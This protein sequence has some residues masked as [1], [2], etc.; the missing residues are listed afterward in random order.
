M[1]RVRDQRALH[2]PVTRARRGRKGRDRSRVPLP[3]GIGSVAPAA[4][5]H[6][7]RSATPPAA[8]H[9][10]CQT[11][12]QGKNDS[13]GGQSFCRN[14][15][16]QRIRWCRAGKPPAQAG[17]IP[18][19]KLSRQPTGRFHKEQKWI[20]SWLTHPG[21]SAQECRVESDDS[22]LTK[23]SGPNAGQFPHWKS[24]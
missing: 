19:F 9:S 24:G 18:R 6:S 13:L 12:A 14:T 2:S 3:S 11:E 7:G 23:L 5:L 20:G 22:E 16:R 21:R 8:S 17:A 15:S 10:Q 4:R 1:G